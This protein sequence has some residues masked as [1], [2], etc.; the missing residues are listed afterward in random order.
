MCNF[1]TCVI[2]FKL[3][4]SGILKVQRY[5]K[6]PN[7]TQNLSVWDT[8]VLSRTRLQALCTVC[9]FWWGLPPFFCLFNFKL[10]MHLQIQTCAHSASQW[11]Y[12]YHP[13]G[14][15]QPKP[16]ESAGKGCDSSVLMPTNRR[17]S[18]TACSTSEH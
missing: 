4:V 14:F 11:G 2:M 10:F 13:R 8:F 18:G 5:P 15:P 16:A 12:M 6:Y 7:P 17:M 3:V 9:T 1:H